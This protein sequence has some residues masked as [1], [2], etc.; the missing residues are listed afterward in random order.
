LILKKQLLK[1]CG[2]DDG[3]PERKTAIA[4]RN[5][6]LSEH[7]EAATVQPVEGTAKQRE[8][9]KYASAQAYPFQAGPLAQGHANRNYHIHNR[10]VK[11][12]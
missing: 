3:L 7:L 8:V 10:F 11:A 12:T 2:G 9:L 6:C 5:F 1:K 4:R